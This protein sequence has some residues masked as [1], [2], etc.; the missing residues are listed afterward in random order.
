MK[1]IYTDFEIKL[2]EILNDTS[3]KYKS[4]TD[5]RKRLYEDFIYTSQAS[6]SR[7]LK[8]IGAVLNEDGWRLKSDNEYNIYKH[9]FQQTFTECTDSNSFYMKNIQVAFLKTK[10]FFNRK[11]AKIIEETFSDNVL[12]TNC[13]NDDG[14]IIYYSPNRN[15]Q[16]MTDLEKLF[17]RGNAVDSNANPIELE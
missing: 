17:G 7:G 15:N 13:M 4:Q 8:N 5:I 2:I 9:I 10:P 12:G 6:I 1:K 14:I 3:K 11:L 16:F